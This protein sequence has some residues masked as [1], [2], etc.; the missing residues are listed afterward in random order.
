MLPTFSFCVPFKIRSNIEENATEDTV[1]NIQVTDFYEM[2]DSFCGA[3][4]LTYTDGNISDMRVLIVSRD[5]EGNLE[6][7]RWIPA[8]PPSSQLD[9][10]VA[11]SVKSYLNQQPNQRELSGKTFYARSLPSG[12]QLVNRIDLDAMN[13]GEMNYVQSK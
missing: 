9:I 8:F 7:A 11:N 10:A 1:F 13:Q 4:A 2:N 12:A 5:M 3:T 6:P